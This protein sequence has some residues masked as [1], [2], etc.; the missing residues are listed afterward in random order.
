MSDDLI[1]GK[2]YAVYKNILKKALSFLINAARHS[3]VTDYKSY[4]LSITLTMKIRDSKVNGRHASIT[5]KNKPS[6]DTVRHELETDTTIID[7]ADLSVFM[8]S[9]TFGHLL[10]EIKQD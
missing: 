8:D 3:I 6:E 4:D 1:R 10:T 7:R 9:D 2:G 5:V